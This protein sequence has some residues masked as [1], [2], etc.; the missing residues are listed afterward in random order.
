MHRV[1][2]A[3]LAVLATLAL[4]LAAPAL[5]QS[6]GVDVADNSFSPGTLT[7]AA[8]DTVMWQVSGTNPHTI[9]A[10]DGSF[11]QSVGNGDTFEQT[12]DTPGTYAYYC[13]IHGAS[14]GVGMSGTV[15]VEA[16]AAPSETA[17]PTDAPT[18]DPTEDGAGELPATGTT[19][20]LLVAAAAIALVAGGGALAAR[21]ARG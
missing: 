5:A 18:A 10:E 14:G 11:D 13:R 3:A 17:S 20:W 4:A 1:R 9:T 6:S 7:V 2:T 16:V 8:G 19:P 21:R 15:V 12:F